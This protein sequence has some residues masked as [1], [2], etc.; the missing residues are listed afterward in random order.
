MDAS[1]KHSSII[2]SITIQL[3]VSPTINLAEG[4]VPSL[5]LSSTHRG[6]SCAKE[7]DLGSFSAIDHMILSFREGTP[8][9]EKC[10]HHVEHLE[11]D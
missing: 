4:T 6:E 7:S 2:E 1:H 5:F 11:I 9:L 8:L 10:E 3:V